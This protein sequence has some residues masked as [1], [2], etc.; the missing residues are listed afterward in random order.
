MFARRANPVNTYAQVA[1][2]AGEIQEKIED[3]AG[4][5]DMNSTSIKNMMIV[6]PAV[7]SIKNKID[8]DLE[9]L[10]VLAKELEKKCLTLQSIMKG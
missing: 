9:E 8:A 4:L 7:K 3:S 2:L 10:Y 6:N 5:I 1:I